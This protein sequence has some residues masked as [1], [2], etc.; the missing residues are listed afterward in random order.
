[1]TTKFCPH[2]KKEREARG[3]NLHIISCKAKTQM[4]V[5]RKR[6]ANQTANMPPTVAD[7]F[8]KKAQEAGGGR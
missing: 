5:L 3:F 6:Y 7:R 2:C 8:L 4:E 1:M